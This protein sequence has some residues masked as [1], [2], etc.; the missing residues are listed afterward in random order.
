M[1]VPVHAAMLVTIAGFQDDQ[2]ASQMMQN[3]NAAV[4]RD[5]GFAME[6]HT[7]QRLAY[8]HEC[9]LGG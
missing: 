5:N 3:V 1:L 2:G 8:V 7:A 4:M 6:W 9:R